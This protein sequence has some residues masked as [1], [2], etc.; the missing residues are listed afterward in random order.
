MTIIEDSVVTVADVE[1]VIAAIESADLEAP[2]EEAAPRLRLTLPRRRPLPPGISEPVSQAFAPGIRAGLG[3]DIG[4]AI[5]FVCGEQLDRWGVSAED[6][7]RRAVSNVRVRV[8]RRK[9]FALIHEAI[10]GVPTLGFQSREG[11]ASSLLVLPDELVRVLGRREGIVLAPMRDLVLLM[12]LDAD[13]ELAYWVLEEFAQADPNA[14][15]LPLFALLCGKLEKV[16]GFPAL[17]RGA[18]RH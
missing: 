13:A 9:R 16:V 12:P 2:W 7:F 6:A 8:R 1:E 15:D 5:L 3:L 17:P 11:W 18:L 10:C 4:P 14:L